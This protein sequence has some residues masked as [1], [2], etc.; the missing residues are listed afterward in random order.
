MIRCVGFSLVAV[1]VA[2]GTAA[3]HGPQIQVTNDKPGSITTRRLLLDG[4]YSDSLTLVTRVYVM[5]LVENLGAWYSRPNPALLPDQTPE[6]FSGPGLAYGYGYDPF[7][8]TTP[9]PVGVKFQLSFVAGLKRWDGTA[10]MDA[11]AAEMESFTG[12]NPSAPTGMARTSDSGPFATLAFPTAGISY[13]TDGAETH[14]TVRFRLLGDGASPTSAAADGVYLL[15]L[16]LGLS[17]ATP[18]ASTPFYFVLEKNARAQV[19][20]AAASLGF[21][22]SLVQSLLVPEPTAG[23]LAVAAMG[24]LIGSSRRRREAMPT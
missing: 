13:A 17:G 22:A 18:A 9:F 23:T 6:F 21:N 5:P 4:P 7:A 24:V 20:A 3:A 11:G 8:A 2:V 14:S 15:S 19:Q 1:L 10:F 16:Q 12:G